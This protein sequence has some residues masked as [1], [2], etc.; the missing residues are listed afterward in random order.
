MQI[1]DL[2]SRSLQGS[3]T[4]CAFFHGVLAR[5]SSTA[6]LIVQSLR[7]LVLNIDN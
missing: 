1:L 5:T 3:V 4:A 2:L 6:C 7:N